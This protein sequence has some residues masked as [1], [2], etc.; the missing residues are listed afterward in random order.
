VFVRAGDNCAIDAAASK[1]DRAVPRSM[2]EKKCAFGAWI[3]IAPEGVRGRSTSR[4]TSVYVH[5]NLWR[6]E[7]G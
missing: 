2:L 5:V 7:A 1:V 4:S 6:A 3:G